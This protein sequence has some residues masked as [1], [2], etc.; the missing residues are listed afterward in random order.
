MADGKK[1]PTLEQRVEKLEQTVKG[2]RRSSFKTG[3]R[4]RPQPEP[5]AKKGD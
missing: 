3:P 1:E 5:K 4:P 2:L